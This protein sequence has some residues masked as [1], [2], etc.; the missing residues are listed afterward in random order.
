MADNART[1]EREVKLRDFHG[2]TDEGVNSWLK[3]CH[4]AFEFAEMTDARRMALRLGM[5]MVGVASNWLDSVDNDTRTN[6][7]RLSEAMRMRFEYA[8]T[9]LQ[10]RRQMDNL[11]Q[12]GC[13]N[14]PIE[15]SVIDPTKCVLFKMSL[16]FYILAI[17]SHV[18]GCHMLV[19]SQIG[20]LI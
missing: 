16:P 1:V 6:I 2:R 7:W 19:S 13:Y 12:E 3:E 18:T 9:P 20:P 8:K 5:A 17:S 15:Y 10:M 4:R 14:F 11:R